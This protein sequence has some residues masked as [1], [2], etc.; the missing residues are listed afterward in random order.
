MYKS[1][2]IKTSVSKVSEKQLSRTKKAGRATEFS[3]SVSTWFLQ[4]AP[5][6]AVECVPRPAC[7]KSHLFQKRS[8][9]LLHLLIDTVPLRSIPSADGNSS[10]SMLCAVVPKI[11]LF[12]R[13][14]L[15]SHSV[16]NNRVALA[17][18]RKSHYKR[19]PPGS[20]AGRMVSTASL[21]QRLSVIKHS[22]TAAGHAGGW[23]PSL[24]PEPQP[25]SVGPAGRLPP[26]P[27]PSLQPAPPPV[28]QQGPQAATRA[29]QAAP[30]PASPPCSAESPVPGSGHRPRLQSW[31]GPG[32]HLPSHE[33]G[34]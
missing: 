11:F 4:G 24:L 22:V 29:A 1:K 19:N 14:A 8:K 2:G 12:P 7:C 5:L 20:P 10:F 31:A 27:G 23:P 28:A 34:F 13:Q 16:L 25:V 32:S 21:E 18:Q 15:K 6:G 30:D 17:F 9:M 33:E 26:T 3:R